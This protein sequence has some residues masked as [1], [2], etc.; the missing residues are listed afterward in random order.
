MCFIYDVLWSIMSYESLIET[1]NFKC[2]KDI[3]D[4]ILSIQNDPCI[5]TDHMNIFKYLDDKMDGYRFDWDGKILGTE[6]GD[7]GIVTNSIHDRDD[8]AILRLLS[9]Y[10]NTD[11]NEHIQKYTNLQISVGAFTCDSH[12]LLGIIITEKNID[13]EALWEDKWGKYY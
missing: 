8:V 1:S 2:I 7:V 6:I 11:F 9:G 3:L 5:E 12:A 4:I 10:L 13:I